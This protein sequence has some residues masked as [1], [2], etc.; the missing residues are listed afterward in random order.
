M[1]YI[2]KN[3]KKEEYKE[4]LQG[5]NEKHEYSE[6][7]V[8]WE[9]VY[10]VPCMSVDSKIDPFSKEDFVKKTGSKR[11]TMGDLMDKSAELSEKRKSITGEDPIQR[12]FFDKYAKKRK[13][14]LHPNDPKRYS[15]LNKMGA[16]FTMGG[17]D[18]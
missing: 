9:R 10:T 14:K 2:Y 8:K 4:I 1:I 15:K 17:S 18:E 12:K 6:N 16:S 7:G 3:P 13:G 5:M 11:G